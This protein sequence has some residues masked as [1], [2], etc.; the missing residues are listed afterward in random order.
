M[1]TNDL[2]VALRGLRKGKAHAAINIS[3]LSIGMAVSLLIGIWIWGEMRY[4]TGIPGHGRI[5]QVYQSSIV[6]GEKHTNEVTPLP[7]AN[8]L[9]THYGGHFKYVVLSSWTSTHL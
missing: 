2:K 5:A 6:N 3:G 1:L 7:L 4:N 8:E 9:R